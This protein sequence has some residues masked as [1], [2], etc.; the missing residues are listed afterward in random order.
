MNR[1][2]FLKISS[3]LTF[4]FLLTRKNVFAPKNRLEQKVNVNLPSYSLT[5]MN[6]LGGDLKETFIFPVGIGKGYGEKRQTPIGTGFIYEKRKEI[7]FRYEKERPNRKKG[8]LIN[9]TNTYDEHGKPK[10]YPM[11]YSQMRGLGMKIKTDSFNY[12]TDFVIHSTTD[13]FTVGTPTSD[14]CLRVRMEDML[15]LYDKISPLIRQGILKKI[16]PIK[17]SYNLVELDQETIKLHAN[18]YN[19]N[20]DTIQEFKEKIT[21]TDFNKED[22]DYNKMKKE[23]ALANK[24]FSVAHKQIL[25][26]LSKHHPHNFVPLYLKE[27]LHKTYKISN[28]LRG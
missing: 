13:E 18:I 11:P 2:D 4:N 28:F 3:L 5:L 14:G 26:I 15:N 6:F 20:I 19:K 25:N 23:F 27:N 17:I 22:F 7:T 16:V 24:E 9:W 1:R 8:D 21:E 12:S 10:S